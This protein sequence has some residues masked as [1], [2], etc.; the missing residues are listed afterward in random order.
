MRWLNLSNSVDLSAVIKN[1]DRK[2]VEFEE[3]SK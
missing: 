1:I 3:M 2:N